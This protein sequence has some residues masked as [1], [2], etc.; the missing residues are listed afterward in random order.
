MKVANVLGS[1]EH[2]THFSSF[3]IYSVSCFFLHPLGGWPKCIDYISGF[4][5]FLVSSWVQQQE[6]QT[7]DKDKEGE[8]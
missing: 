3:Q 5:C 8:E 6:A 4:V 1:G 2:M 7:E